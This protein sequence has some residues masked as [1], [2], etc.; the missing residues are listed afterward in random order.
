MNIN[1]INSLINYI[2]NINIYNTVYNYLIDDNIKIRDNDTFINKVKYFLLRYKRIIA[3]VLLI[4]LLIIGYKCKIH[5]LDFKKKGNT[6]ILKGGDEGQGAPEGGAPE[7]TGAAV[8]DATAA[9][10]EA[11]AAAGAGGPGE[12]KKGMLAKGASKVF[13][14]GAQ[15][16]QDFKEFAPW[17]YGL[18]YSIA[19]TVLIFMIFMPSIGFLI[20]GIVCYSLLRGKIGYIKSL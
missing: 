19:I 7:G 18:L 6:Y 10:A 8:T 11:P 20:V 4:I 1:N 15:R 16:A 13:D 9:V 14:F 2:S 12:K 3:I 5:F 17:L